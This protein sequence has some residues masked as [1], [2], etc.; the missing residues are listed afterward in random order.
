MKTIFNY[1]AI[2]FTDVKSHQPCSTIRIR[3]YDIRKYIPY[4]L[5]KYETEKVLDIMYDIFKEKLGIN[6]SFKLTK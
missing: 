6:E 4:T 3:N 5:I 1:K 2:Y